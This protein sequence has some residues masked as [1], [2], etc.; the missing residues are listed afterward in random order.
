[1]MGAEIDNGQSFSA[2]GLSRDFSKIVAILAD[3]QMHSTFAEP[4]LSLERDQLANSLQSTSTISG[5]MI[6]R[7]YL[8]L[9]AAPS[10]PSLRNASQ[11]TVGGITQADL[12][13]YTQS[14]W[15]PDLTTIAVVG[16][17]TPDEVRTV[18]QNAFGGWS[19][20]GPKPDPEAMAFPAAHSGHD[21]IGTD[22]SQVY[23]RIGQPAVSRNSPDYDTFL[24]LNQILGAGGAFESRLWQEM[25]QKRGLVYS[26]ASSV[27]AG[28]DRGDFKVEIDAPA[29]RVVEAVNFV[30]S[31]FITLQTHPVTQ[32]ELN[33]AKLR[34]VSNALLDEASAD[35][36]AQQL[37]DIGTNGLP[38]DYYRTLNDRFANI[39]AADVQRVA[40][41]YLD[42]AAL[43]EYPIPVPRVHG[44]ADFSRRPISLDRGRA[45]RRVQARNASRAQSRDGRDASRPSDCNR[46]RFAS[47]ARCC[48]EGLRPLACGECIRSRDRLTSRRCA[49]ARTQRVDCAHD[50]ARAGQSARR[51]AA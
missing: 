25:R 16:D 14:Y 32:T 15:R 17:V 46:R 7:A 29:S 45:Y 36:E 11:T 31:E 2:R 34:L 20:Q 39:T 51:V 48:C 19:A 33:D 47:C 3:G 38:L 43:V 44:H 10:D 12:L 6:D 18:L 13:A 49:H 1:M 5:V 41:K 37:L 42:P 23:V 24:V 8:R 27:D 50:D 40:Q 35:G 30:R 21:Y 4:W 28:R 26:V 9:L 22:A